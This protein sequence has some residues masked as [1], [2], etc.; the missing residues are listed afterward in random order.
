MG[1]MEFE[2]LCRSWIL[3]GMV[4]R[5]SRLTAD[6]RVPSPGKLAGLKQVLVR[7][8]ACREWSIRFGVRSLVQTQHGG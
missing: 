4:A 7:F 6:R 5:D 8:L 2:D 3:N 1:P